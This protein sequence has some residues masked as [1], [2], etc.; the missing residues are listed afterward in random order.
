MQ[1]SAA[2]KINYDDYEEGEMIDASGKT[3]IKYLW[4]WL[5]CLPAVIF[6]GWI[7]GHRLKN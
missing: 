2:G 3:W 6:E 5:W 7:A 1:K 4:L